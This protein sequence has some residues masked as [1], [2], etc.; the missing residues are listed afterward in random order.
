MSTPKGLKD[1][2]LITKKIVLLGF[3]VSA[4]AY[5]ACPRE[6]VSYYLKQGFKQEQI[7]QLCTMPDSSRQSLEKTTNKIQQEPHS[8]ESKK[9]SKALEDAPIVRHE[10]A[11]IY[12][13][14]DAVFLATSIEGYDVEV[15]EN[16]IIFTRKECFNF[17]QKDWNGFQNSACPHVKY[18]I[19]SGGLKIKDRD[20]G[21]F[22][23]GSTALYISGNIKAE[24]LDLGQFN[25]NQQE[26]IRRIIQKNT[27]ML[28][29]D[30]RSG[31][32]QD[33]VEAILLRLAG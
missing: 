30:V 1:F 13:N 22:G 18:T 31:M 23:L 12:G 15:T 32:P 9:K 11:G 2:P 28:K 8:V 3:L 26:D 21:F 10:S 27:D 29:I 33:K 16:M 7:V 5:A 4:Q 6:D 24:I 19:I 20:N 14:P 25:Q 17:G